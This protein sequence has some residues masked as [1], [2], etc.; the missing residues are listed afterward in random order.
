MPCAFSPDGALALSA[1][2]E[3]GL[4]DNTLRLWEVASG[5]ELRRFEGH[6]DEV[7]ACAFSP[8]GALALSASRD[9][10]LRLWEVASGRELRR[11]EGHTTG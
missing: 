2:G 4:S 1:S 3:F 9:R 5:R 8:D 11:F 7:L 10:T 6:T